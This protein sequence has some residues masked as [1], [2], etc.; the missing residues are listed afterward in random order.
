MDGPVADAYDH[1]VNILITGFVPWGKQRVNPSGEL[2][3]ALGGHLLP[4]DFDGAGREL[5]RLIRRNR[6]QAVVMMGLAPGRKR[7][8]LEAVALN[9]EHHDEQGKDRRWLRRIRR[10]GPLALESRLPLGRI[11]DQLAKAGVPVA[12]SHHAGTY[13]CNRVFYEGLSACSVPCGFIHVPP[14]TAMS[15]SRQIRAIRAILR[16]IDGS[17]PAATP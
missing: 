6:P 2:A 13:V 12:I 11:V 10:S 17:S 9:V 7:I 1:A 14:F 5:R 3:A 16:A 8:S 4:V 15:Q